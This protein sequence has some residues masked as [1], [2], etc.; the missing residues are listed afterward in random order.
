[1]NN[2]GTKQVSIMKQTA[3]WREKDGEYRACLKY[4]VPVFVEEIYKMQRLEVSGAVRPIYGSL[5]VKR[6]NLQWYKIGSWDDLAQRLG[7]TPE[8]WETVARFSTRYLF[9]EGPDRSRGPA[10]LL[11]TGSLY[12][13]VKQRRRE[14]QQ[15]TCV[16]ESTVLACTGPTSS[17]GDARGI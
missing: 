9:P 17:C 16:Q 8:K 14:E 5:G 6:L 7:H 11:D 10:S 2:T 15:P 3:F 4:S 12:S 13:H 1:V